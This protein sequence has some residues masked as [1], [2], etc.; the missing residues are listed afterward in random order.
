MH[1]LKGGGG[2]TRF[3]TKGV[4]LWSVIRGTLVR[5]FLPGGVKN[6]PSKIKYF[7]RGLDGKNLEV[8]FTT[9]QIRA[10]PVISFPSSSLVPV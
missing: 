4:G 1:L 8:D 10:D 2:G 3:L 5:R 9:G 6:I 7:R